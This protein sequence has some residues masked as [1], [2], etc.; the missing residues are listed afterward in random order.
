MPPEALSE[1][2]AQLRDIHE[3]AVPGWWPLPLGWWLVLAFVTIVIGLGIWFY[4]TERRRLRPYFV[5]RRATREL[6]NRRNSGEIDPLE[7]A[8]KVNLLFKELIVRVEKR[9]EALTMS[10]SQWLDLLADRFADNSFIRGPGACLG[11]NRYMSGVFSDDGL[12]ELVKQTLLR[13]APARKSTD[14]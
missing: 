7:Y 11:A 1:V 6:N 9:E 4:K 14:A 10:G 12:Q 13:A 2:L 3:P 8:T 5:I